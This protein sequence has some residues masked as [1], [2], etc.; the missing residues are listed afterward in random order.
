[1]R[2]ATWNVNSLRVRLPHVIDWLQENPVDVL[3]LQEIKQQDPDFPHQALQAIGY[4]AVCSGQKTYNG[5]ALLSRHAI[6]DVETGLPEHDD[7]QRRLI[8]A[9]IAGIRIVNVYIPNGEKPESDKF[10]YKLDWLERLRNY[11]QAALQVYSRLVIVGDFNIAPDSRDIH[12]PEAWTNKILCTVQER[13]AL[14]AITD[15][16]LSDSFRLCTQ[17][18]GFYSWW[19]YRA[20]AF[21]RDRGLRIDLILCSSALKASCQSCIIDKTPRGW[22]RPSDHAPVIADFSLTNNE[23][24][25]EIS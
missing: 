18:A 5:V 14:T 16:G 6:N 15:C 10:H 21:R 17:E 4:H 9:T 24:P 22:E 11:L 8:A 23:T 25:H 12:D 3:A 7:P 20:A 19:D 1:M 13:E 2:I